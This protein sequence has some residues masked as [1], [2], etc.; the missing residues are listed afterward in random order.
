LLFRDGERAVATNIVE[1]TTTANPFTAGTLSAEYAAAAAPVLSSFVAIRL[2]RSLPNIVLV[3][4]RRGALRQA[5]IGM[6]SRQMMQL[7]GN[8][9]R[10]FTLYCPIGHER[11]AAEIFTPELMQVFSESLPG[12]DI[13]LCDEWLFVYDEGR[14]FSTPEALERIERVALR[15]QDEIVR[16]DFASLHSEPLAAVA[17]TPIARM[18][19]AQFATVIVVSVVAAA[20]AGLWAIVAH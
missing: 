4:A 6:G 1:S 12:G 10:E 14:R 16:R 17:A 15:V 19:G 18:R 20:L 5:R 9:D 13:E 7:P 2:H 11:V 3:N 8:Y